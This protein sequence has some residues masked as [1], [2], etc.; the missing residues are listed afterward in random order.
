VLRAHDLRDDQEGNWICGQGQVRKGTACQGWWE[1][2]VE[3][4][5]EYEFDLRRWP[6]EAGHR[7]SGGI[8]GDDVTYREDGILPGR[9]GMYSGGVALD[10]DTAGLAI[11]GFKEQWVA[12]KPE[13]RGAVFRMRL[14]EGP[15][16]VRARFSSSAGFNTAAYYVYVRRV[17]SSVVAQS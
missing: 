3:S 6:E 1:I 13:D 16:H 12:V 4:E 11:S 9:E 14:P 2:L 7:V 5:G 15:R 8:E 10:I 17:C